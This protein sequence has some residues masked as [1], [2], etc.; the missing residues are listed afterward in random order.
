MGLTY[1]FLYSE[2]LLEIAR[3]FNGGSD[4]LFR[5]GIC[6][7]FTVKACGIWNVFDITL[8]PGDFLTK[9][10]TFSRMFC[11]KHHLLFQVYKI[12]ADTIRVELIVSEITRYQEIWEM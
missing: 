7:I 8:I 5:F 9:E 2:L 1:R 11:A 3:K 4:S 10:A 12:S 6:S